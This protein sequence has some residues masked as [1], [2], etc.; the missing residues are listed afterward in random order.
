MR[1]NL[2]AA[3]N[4]ILFTHELIGFGLFIQLK[5][6]FGIKWNTYG[7]GLSFRTIE[8]IDYVNISSEIFNLSAFSVSDH[9]HYRPK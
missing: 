1:L 4:Q 6:I 2:S 7:F 8:V 9:P 5:S 3:V